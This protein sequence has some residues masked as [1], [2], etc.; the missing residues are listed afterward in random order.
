MFLLHGLRIRQQQHIKL[1]ISHLTAKA[2][3]RCSTPCGPQCGARRAWMDA[4]GLVEATVAA[5][6]F[7]EEGDENEVVFGGNFLVD[8]F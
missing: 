2:A 3:A 7:E 5:H 6:A 1:T 4:V 8:G